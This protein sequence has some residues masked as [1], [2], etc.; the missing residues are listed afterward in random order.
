MRQTIILP[1]A[2]AIAFS[3][4][5][6]K[7][8]E[9][10]NVSIPKTEEA[11][12][13]SVPQIIK[14]M[15][16]TLGKSLDYSTEGEA[17]LNKIQKTLDY[18]KLTAKQKKFLENRHYY[19]DGPCAS[20]WDT[21]TSQCDQ[22]NGIRNVTASSSLKSTA[23]IN[24]LPTNANNSSFKDAWVEGVA[25][26][27][28][29]EHITFHFKPKTL[30]IYD[31]N[32][33][34]GYVKSEKA[35]RENSRPK[36]L[37]MYVDNKP[38]A[39][40]N[41]QDIRQEQ[42]FT[43]EPAIGDGEMRYLFSE[44]AKGEPERTVKFEIMEVYPGEKYDDTVISLID[45][46]RFGGCCFSAGTQIAMADNSQKNIEAVKAGDMVKSW[47][48]GKKMLVNTKVSKL[49]SATHSG[50]LKLKLAEGEIITT[51]DHPFWANKNAW[52]K[53]GALK[54]GSKVFIPEKNEYSQI[55]SIENIDEK[56]TAY[57]IEV[58]GSDNFVANGILV[59]VE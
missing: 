18:N 33:A 9:Q 48:F 53:A 42:I 31:I 41:L 35:Y 23:T 38:V 3:L 58:E 46:G 40:L 37:K 29:G 15:H 24:Y 47:D 6:C 1:L 4:A 51:S 26:Y 45:M 52:V 32:I 57:T 10:G 54:A 36:K 56:Q 21:C 19:V 27:G 28:I 11:A 7:E 50:L 13:K 30:K 25:G 49:L 8:K 34:N 39:I 14:E 16:P 44:E 20:Y 55:T 2:F 12:E 5:S 17:E 59:R 22:G 43:F